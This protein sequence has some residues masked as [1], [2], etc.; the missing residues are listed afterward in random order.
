MNKYVT[1]PEDLQTTYDETKMGFLSI[2]LR[3][4]KEA[5]F[6]IEKAKAFK[7][8][9]SAYNDPNE[10]IK[11]GD[12]QNSLCEAA[13][14]STK[15]R[16]YLKPEDI[17]LILSEFSEEFL[18]PAGN[19]FVDELANRYLLT[20]GDALGGRMRN[21]IGGI[22][23]EKLTQQIVAT[24][25][26]RNYEF[27][28]YDKRANKWVEGATFRAEISSDVKAI[29]W[30]VNQQT[31]LLYYDLT[32]PIVKKNIDIVVFNNTDVNISNT[33]QFN[34]FKN[35]PTN[36]HILGELKGGIDPAGADEHWKTANTALSRIRDS[37]SRENKSIFTLF[38]GAAIEASMAREIYNQCISGEL[39]NCANLTKDNQ[40][41]EICDWLICK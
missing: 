28:Y 35:N 31:R 24:L 27:C 33:K 39:T 10:L 21:I 26:V 25:D 1:T 38:I 15:A 19:N 34:E 13:G 14:V 22:A 30:R 9:V 23:G 16:G 20:L 32:V 40:L 6:Y 11:I 18:I 4:S 2:T 37:F 29:R 36:Y 7:N 41:V 12:I 17:E 8:I 3:K 5:C